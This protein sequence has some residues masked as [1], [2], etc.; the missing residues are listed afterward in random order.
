MQIQQM[1]IES[2]PAIIYGSQ[3]DKLFIAVH[4]DM[5]S[6]SDPIIA[7]LAEVAVAKGYQVLSFDLPEHGDR[8]DKTR[9]CNPQNAIEDLGKIIQYAHAYSDEIS[10]FGCSI[11]AYFSMLAYRDEVI[12]QALFLS[13]I[14]DMKHLIENM[15]LWFDVSEEKLRWEK[16]VATPAK[17]LCWNYYQYV[18]GHPVRWNTP[19]AILCGARDNLCET[20]YIHAFAEKTSADFT[21]LEYG[22]H[23]FHTDDQLSLFQEW[24]KTKIGEQ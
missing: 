18:C 4:G 2:I 22:E 23:W 9:L 16:E 19:T 14:L 21:I 13:P 5:A 11:G 3:S 7:L 10:L 24:L 17:T 12:R 6:K 8:K 1:Q 20:E 15:M